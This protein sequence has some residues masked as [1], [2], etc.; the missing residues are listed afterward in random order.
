MSIVILIV[1]VI[2]LFYVL[3]MYKYD[4]S[5]YKEESGNNFFSVMMDKGKYGEYLSFNWLEKIRGEHKI[6]TNVYLPKGNGETTEVDL[7][8]I[9]E[10]GIYVLESK[11]YSG[12]IFGDE[13][14]KYWMQ[15]LE[16]RH[17]EKFYNPIWQNNTHIKYLIK[18]LNANEEFIKSIIVFSDRCTIK[19]MEVSSENV[20][21]INC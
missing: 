11:N 4:K 21:V 8:Y 10:T 9:H 13:K 16:N 6:L 1:L 17:K 15:T 20:S 14:S 5:K 19:K 7:I 18:L 3:R 12:W 2:F